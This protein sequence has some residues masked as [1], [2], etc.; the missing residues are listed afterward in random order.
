M[1]QWNDGV[2]SNAMEQS[3]SWEVIRS[4]A[5]QEI[6][7]ILWNT[8]VHLHIHKIPP[9]V[10]TSASLNITAWRMRHFHITILHRHFSASVRMSRSQ[11]NSKQNTTL[12]PDTWP[13]ITALP[14]VMFVVAKHERDWQEERSVILLWKKYNLERLNDVGGTRLRSQEVSSIKNSIRMSVGIQS[15]TLHYQK[16]RTQ[17]KISGEGIIS[18]GSANTADK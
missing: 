18:R 10:L 9:P 16:S 5:S 7:R 6:P 13:K 17:S 14:N 2:I 11:V 12:M 3:P 15:I 8:K 1:E 4:S